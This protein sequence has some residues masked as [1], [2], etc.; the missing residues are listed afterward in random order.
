MEDKKG[1]ALAAVITCVVLTAVLYSF[2]RNLIPSAPPLVVADPDAVASEDVEDRASDGVTVEVTPQTVQSLIAS[3]K[4]YGSYRRSISVEYYAD[5]QRIGGVSAQVWEEDHWVRTS[6]VL[7]SGLT[8]HAIV[9]DDRLW[10]WYEGDERVYQGPASEKTADLSQRLP[11]YEDVLALDKAS[12]TAAGYVERDGQ[13]C[14]YVEAK[15]PELGYVERYWISETSGLLAAAEMEQD[16]ELIYA[17]TSQQVVSPLEQ[18]DSVFTLPDGTVLHGPS[19]GSS[20]P[21]PKSSSRPNVITSS[22]LS[23]SR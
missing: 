22:R 13:P 16:G 20:S 15:T 14:V 5:G 6:T 17:M 10:L 3:L 1:T 4:R 21:S 19:S 18:T 2:F 12:I 9:G 23:P 11:T 8:E 7:D